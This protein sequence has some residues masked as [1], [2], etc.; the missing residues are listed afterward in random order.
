MTA[1]AK[2]VLLLASTT[3]ALVS[4]CG[5][6]GSEGTDIPGEVSVDLEQRNDANGRGAPRRTVD[7]SGRVRPAT[8]STAIAAPTYNKPANVNG[9][10]SSASRDASGAEMPNNTAAKLQRITPRVLI[11]APCGAKRA[12]H[13]VCRVTP[14]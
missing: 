8:G 3:A 12:S 1:S 5:G 7:A 9:P 11:G 2:V 4:G 14:A 10:R 6:S 13:R